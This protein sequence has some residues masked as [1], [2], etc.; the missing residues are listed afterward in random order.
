MVG[1]RYDVL[2]LSCSNITSCK[3]LDVE[4]YRDRMDAFSQAAVPASEHCSRQVAEGTVWI[5]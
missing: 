1:L 2:P 3:R 4:R 5:K